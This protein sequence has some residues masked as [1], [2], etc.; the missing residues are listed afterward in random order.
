MFRRRNR[1]GRNQ[2]HNLARSRGG[3]SEDYN[4]ILIKIERHN[5]LHKIFGLRTIR[6][7]IQML[8]RLDRIK[9]RKEADHAQLSNLP[10]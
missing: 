1:W 9:K 7:V 3:S 2:H 5:L 10:H 4:L 6:E 8:E